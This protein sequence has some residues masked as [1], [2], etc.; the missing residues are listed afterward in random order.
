MLEEKDAM[1]I[2]QRY[3]HDILNELQLVSGYLQLGNAKK[4]EELL[5]NFFEHMQEERKLTQL[6]IPA[7][8]LWLIEFNHTHPRY[9]LTY[10][11]WADGNWEPLDRILL[12]KA[13]AIIGLLDRNLTDGEV[14]SIHICLKEEKSDPFVKMMEVSMKGPDIDKLK[15]EEMKDI[16]VSYREESISFVFSTTV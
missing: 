2:L 16:A 6:Q 11:V 9:Q 1:L 8:S 15:L 3:R 4:A 5:Q 14:Y 10:E 12:E 7:F 13:N